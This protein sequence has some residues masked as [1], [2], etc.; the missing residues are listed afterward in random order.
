MLEVEPRRSS[1]RMSKRTF[2]KR[3]ALQVADAASQ[4]IFILSEPK[5]D[6][7]FHGHDDYA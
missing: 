3:P 4:S 5:I 2:A 6:A 1:C 7:R